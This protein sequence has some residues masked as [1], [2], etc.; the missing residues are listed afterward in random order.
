M[1][2]IA[3]KARSE[4]APAKP[5]PQNVGGIADTKDTGTIGG[6]VLFK[7]TKPESKPISDIAGNAFC[8][9][10]HKDKLPLRDTFVFGKNGANDTL[11]N[12]L[13]YVTKGLEGKEFP[14]LKTPVVLD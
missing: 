13:V 12:V 7:G 9:E 8:Q 10:H 3:T 1:L 6:V 5:V 11:Q 4:D 2:S 14:P